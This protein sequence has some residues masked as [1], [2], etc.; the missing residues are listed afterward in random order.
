VSGAG[1]RGNYDKYLSP[2]SFGERKRT[3][4]FQLKRRGKKRTTPLLPLPSAKW[5]FLDITESKE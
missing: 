3:L 4:S 5:K 1:G 2:A